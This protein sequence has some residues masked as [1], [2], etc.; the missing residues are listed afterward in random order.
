MKSEKGFFTLLFVLLYCTAVAAAETAGPSPFDTFFTGTIQPVLISIFGAVLTAATAYLSKLL[1]DKFGLEISEATQQ[2]LRGIAWDAVH[3]VEEQ[4]AAA[5][6]EKG[7]AWASSDKHAA[8]IN[9][10]LSRVPTLSQEDA[11]SLVK[12]A[13]GKIKGLGA[14][15]AIG[16]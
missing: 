12:S 7:T 9:L 1:K 11:D 15:A 6:K 10:I 3:S 14:S 8:A 2:R 16:S 13:L 4:A 5:L